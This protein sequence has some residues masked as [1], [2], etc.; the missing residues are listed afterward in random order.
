MTLGMMNIS[1]STNTLSNDFWKK[2][3]FDRVFDRW[4]VRVDFY[5]LLCVVEPWKAS[6]TLVIYITWLDK[7]VQAAGWDLGSRWPGVSLF[8][9]SIR[10]RRF[11]EV[12]FFMPRLGWGL[13]RYSFILFHLYYVGRREVNTFEWQNIWYT[14]SKSLPHHVEIIMFIISILCTHFHC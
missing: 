7:L 2:N 13:I 6:A 10:Y 11:T 4:F 9:D 12:T 8:L 14:S 3:G 1:E 5:E